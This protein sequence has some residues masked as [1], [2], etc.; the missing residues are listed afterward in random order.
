MKMTDGISESLFD[1]AAE[2]SEHIE[3]VEV[4]EAAEKKVR[5]AR[6]KLKEAEAELGMASAA[7][8]P[9]TKPKA[10]RKKAEPKE[11]KPV[12]PKPVYRTYE[13][14]ES[15]DLFTY[16]GLDCIVTS[17]ILARTFPLIVEE[18]VFFSAANDGSRISG[19]APAIIKSVTEIEMRAHEYI[20]DLEINGLKYDTD[21]NSR[22][23]ER[24]MGDIEV[25]QDRIFTVTGQFNW[26]SGVE[27]QDLLYN[28][29][30]FT[31]PF[32]TK[33]GD[34]STDGDALLTLAGLDPMSFKYEAPDPA[35]Q[36]LADM[37]KMKD[38]NAAHNTFVKSYVKDF[39]KRDG[40]I[41][42]SYNLHGTSSFRITGSD[43]NLTQLPRPKHGYNLRE[44]YTVEDGYVFIA[45]DWSS[46]E[47]KILGALSKDES[48]LRAIANGYDFHSFSASQMIGVPYEEFMEVLHSDTDP[49]KKLYKQTRQSAKA[50]TFGILYGSSVNGI[51]MNLNVSKEEAERL[52]NLY[53]KAYPG[54]LKYVQDTHRM[55]EWNQYV[56]T[57]FGQRKQE[58][59]THS[60]FKSTA[61]YNAALRNSQNVRVQSTTSTAGLITFAACN[62]AIKQLGGRSICTVYDSAEFEVPIERAAEAVETI[63][64]YFDNWPV[65][66]FEWLDLPI[67]SE[68]E[69]GVNWGNCE[70]V[71]RGVGQQEIESL[72]LKMAA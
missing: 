64:Y 11:V 35:L 72:L 59:G 67:G 36:W 48:L 3:K 16:A 31:A 47:V 37:A 12:E 22:F 53:F 17:E 10:T 40:R 6:K 71:H 26:N 63:F 49:R 43:P 15:K 34:P 46:A 39:V 60:V 61:A 2:I 52:I 25:L 24:M 20:L 68:V 56:I 21:L 44:C 69:L 27:M 38:I 45:A 5:K 62:E 13:D 19:K 58:Y 18:P 54:V 57:P 66:T 70:T 33:T 8:E 42:P 29:M 23:S 4:V 55:A 28:K 41:H 1:V 65:E 51:A 32:T 9:P 50:L 7:L 30:G 14:F